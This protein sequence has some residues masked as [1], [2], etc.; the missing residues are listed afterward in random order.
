VPIMKPYKLASREFHQADSVV[1]VG[2]V[3]IG[4]GVTVIAGPCAIESRESLWRIA[5]AVRQRGAAIL[6]GGAFKPR[7]S[8]YSFQGLGVEGLELLRE[9]GDTFGMPVVTEVMSIAEVEVVA[10]YADM[11]QIGARNVQNFNL[12]AAVGETNRPVLL[13]RGFATTVREFLMSA[14]YVLSRGNRSL[15]LCERGIKT[16]ETELRY[17]FDVS[18]V[19][20]IKHNTHLPVIVD[21]SHASGRR[22]YV[23]ALALA[24]VAAGADGVVVEVHDCPEAALCDGPQA[25][26]PEMFAEMTRQVGAVAAALGRSLV[27]ARTA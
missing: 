24:G 26:L 14:E 20:L 22:D 16:F 27:P 10:R 23:T 25:L 18:A 12:L 8:P 1:D 3:P 9:A 13:K 15:V 7:T 17:T 19:P 21:P 4:N 5:E 11:I 2:G 6:R